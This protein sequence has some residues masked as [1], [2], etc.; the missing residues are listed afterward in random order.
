MGSPNWA[1]ITTAFATSLVA[2][3][4]IG[5]LYLAWSQLR[6]AHEQTKVQHL[7]EFDREFRSEAL[8]T[9]RSELARQMLAGKRDESTELYRILDFF[10]TIGLL[11]R[12]R[13]SG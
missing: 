2:L 11:S 4:G 5:G 3:T 9:C 8:I 6:Q 13:I 12:F 7:V 1:E 10:E